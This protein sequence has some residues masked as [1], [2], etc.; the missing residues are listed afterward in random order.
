MTEIFLTQLAPLASHDNGVYRVFSCLKGRDA[1][2]RGL[3]ADQKHRL[4]L[5]ASWLIAIAGDMIYFALIMASTLWLDGILGD[6]TI[7]TLVI[8]VLMFVVPAVM[9]RLRGR[10]G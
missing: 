2:E 10:K 7:T 3:A 9:K 8:L 5:L 6:G 4:N 1:T